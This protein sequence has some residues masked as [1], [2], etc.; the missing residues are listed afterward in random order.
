MPTATERLDA[1]IKA[2]AED[3]KI[4][5]DQAKRLRQLGELLCDAT[6]SGNQVSTRNL[7]T[8]IRDWVGEMQRR[9][10]YLAQTQERIKQTMPAGRQVSEKR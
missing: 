10:D 9:Y 8:D 6:T 3:W 4:L 5:K 7:I 1:L 2:R